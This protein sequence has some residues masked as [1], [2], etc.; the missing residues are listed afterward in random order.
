[1]LKLPP[2]PTLDEKSFLLPYT[3]GQSK[4]TLIWWNPTEKKATQLY[5]QVDNIQA[6]EKN[7][8]AKRKL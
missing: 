2:T 8:Q 1:M 3:W 7:M 5:K 4:Q 6:N